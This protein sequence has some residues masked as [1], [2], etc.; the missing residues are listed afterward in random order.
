MELEKTGVFAT[1]KEAKEIREAFN[2]PVIYLSGGTP[3]GGN[4]REILHRI[5]LSHGLPEIK[6]YYGLNENNEFIKEKEN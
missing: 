4:P 1:K 6:G 2:F 5:A 3:L